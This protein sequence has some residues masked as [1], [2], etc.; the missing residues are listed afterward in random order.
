MPATKKKFS[1]KK[2][3]PAIAIVDFEVEFIRDEVPET[4]AFRARPDITYGD[5]VELKRHENDSNGKVLPVLDRIIR[6]SM[7]NTD[8]A[9]T[10]WAPAVKDGK[11]VAPDGK[12]HP[13]EDLPKFTSHEAGSSR[14]RWIELIESDSAYVDF[15][16]VMSLFEYLA[17]EAGRRPTERS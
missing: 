1:R 11:F 13:V 4:H 7:L 9:K 8:G 14:R 3:S 5:M 6:R 12:E 10:G 15:E 2:N 16:T 17:E